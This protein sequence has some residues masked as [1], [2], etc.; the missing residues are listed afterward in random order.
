MSTSIAT[1][2]L[3]NSS[4]SHIPA[5]E[6]ERE[7]NLELQ[8]NELV[9]E[10]FNFGTRFIKDAQARRKYQELVEKIPNTL[11]DEVRLNKVPLHQVADRARFLRNSFM[12]AMRSVSSDIGHAVAS[13]IKKDGRS[14]DWLLDRKAK[15][16]FHCKFS[17]LQNNSQRQK[18]FLAVIESSG[19]VNTTVSDFARYLGKLGKAFIIVSL[20][21]AIY[22][23]CE[24]QDH[25]RAAGQQGTSLATGWMLSMV[26][27]WAGMYC[28]PG[29]IVCVPLGVFL[30]GALGAMGADY[31][32]HWRH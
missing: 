22:Q 27:G 6:S 26:G 7:K 3:I 15:N 18:V 32:W 1:Y 9:N 17:E 16:L 13:S 19:T 23:I 10:L 14:L 28:G 30:G 20:A 8:I 5:L 2:P 21:C 12:S 4:K 31:I 25:W 24:A 29:A 11:R